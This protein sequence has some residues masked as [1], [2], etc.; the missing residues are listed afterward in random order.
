M[1][2]KK[3]HINGYYEAHVNNDEA[4]DHE[5]LVVII[6]FPNDDYE[7]GEVVLTDYQVKYKPKKGDVLMFPATYLNESLPATKTNK[8]EVLQHLVL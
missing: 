8:Y 6:M 7:G 5:S 1:E 2:V 4:E 3:Y